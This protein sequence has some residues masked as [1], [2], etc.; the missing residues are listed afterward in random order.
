M[1]WNWG[2]AGEMERGGKIGDTVWKYNRKKT[3]CWWIG[4]GDDT[5]ARKNGSEGLGLVIEP[6]IKEEHI[7]R[8]ELR[9]ALFWPSYM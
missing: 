5:K 9:K 4:Q 2:Q 6:D 8:G 3:S 1:V 7:C